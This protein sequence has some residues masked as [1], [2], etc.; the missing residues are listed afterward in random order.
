MKPAP[1]R[2]P[3]AGR[4][5]GAACLL[6]VGL[7]AV[8]LAA[9]GGSAAAGV[10]PGAE[11]QES[12]EDAA[13]MAAVFSGFDRPDSPGCAAGALRG[14]EFV[15]RGAYGLAN[16]D[17]GIPLGA[18]SIFRMASVSKQFTAA[19]V[20]LAEERGLLSLE[21][22]IRRHFPDLP[23]WAE[24]VRVRHLVHHTSGI[25]DY[26]TVMALSGYGAD[27]H[28]PD[29]AVLDALRGLERLNF[30]PGTEYLYSNSGYWL[31]AQ[32]I[33]RVSG[34]P[35]RAFAREHLFA[36]LGM[37][38]S[39]FHDRYREVVP[40]RAAGY[41]RRPDTQGESGE[42]SEDGPFEFEVDE[43][44]LEMVGDGGL[45][46]SVNELAQW[47]RMFL[48][49]AAFGPAF[50][51]RLTTPGRF[52]GGA[53]QDYAGGLSLSEYRG[54]PTVSHG[55]GFVGF[56]TY[57]L[58]FPEAAFAAFVLCNAAWADPG[59]SARRIA[60]HFLADEFPAPPPRADAAPAAP[61]NTPIPPGRF[62]AADSASLLTIREPADGDG[63]PEAGA[64]A[65]DF[66]GFELP[67]FLAD[68]EAGGGLAA[69]DEE[70]RFRLLPEGDGFTLRREG[71][72]DFRFARIEPFSPTLRE[73]TGL[74][75]V[76]RCRELGGAAY[77][78]R[79]DARPGITLAFG[80]ET[81]ELRPEFL[82]AGDAAVSSPV[83]SWP[84]GTVRFVPDPEAPERALGFD[85]SVGRARGFRF[86]RD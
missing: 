36:P 51:E 86:V 66:G 8:G 65:L 72:R 62:W 44:T 17:H 26:L 25:R 59:A 50:V 24:P 42:S 1:R 31:L 40:N 82:D 37:E 27:D 79:V 9:F 52:E 38:R 48:D 55:G 15:F 6:L 76:F 54:L 45:Y 7:V 3:A 68:A 64:L 22:P 10:P 2:G 75:G 80:G 28:Y 39:H 35:L 4:P 63:A 13:A 30:P 5:A 43:T 23:E 83:F 57:F 56:R 47:E 81:R 18:D 85:L 20:L 74:A 14:G 61:E 33:R 73:L 58:R 53:A 78:V 12:A 46:T 41:R 32:L 71:Q 29:A 67:L 21:D 49:P 16:L 60:D 19:A 69:A 70:E 11:P 84:G 34:R 77:E